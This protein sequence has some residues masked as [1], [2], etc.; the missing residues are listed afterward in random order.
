MVWGICKED[1][2][3]KYEEEH[4]SGG[5]ETLVSPHICQYVQEKFIYP[6]IY[7]QFNP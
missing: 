7:T 2:Q 6:E 5:E 1:E 4:G 3:N